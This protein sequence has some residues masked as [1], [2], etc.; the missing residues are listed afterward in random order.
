MSPFSPEHF[1]PSF[2]KTVIDGMASNNHPIALLP[3]FL[4][5]IRSAPSFASLSYGLSYWESSDVVAT[6]KGYD[7]SVHRALVTLS[8]VFMVPVTP[9]DSRPKS[10]SFSESDNT[11]SFRQH[12]MKG[13]ESGAQLVQVVTWNDYSESTEVAPSS[14][15]QFVFFDLATYFIA[16]FK[17]GRP[18]KMIQDAIYYLHRRQLVTPGTPHIP[19]DTPMRHGRE[20]P[21]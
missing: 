17:L 10:A 1:P 19:G 8:P 20:L 7:D 15:T 2:W 5:P 13:I 12:W 16:W 11:L 6:Q 9:Q 3:V 4:S 14:G 21:R 18:P